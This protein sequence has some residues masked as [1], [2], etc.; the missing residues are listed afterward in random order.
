ME[1][2]VKPQPLRQQD[3]AAQ[4]EKL[5]CLQGVPVLVTGH[6]GFKGA[7][8]CQWLQRLGARVFGL[9]LDPPPDQPSL[10]DLARVAELLAEDVRGDIRDYALLSAV[11]SRVQPQV[12][13]H[14][15]AQALVQRSYAE[16]RYSFDVNVGGTVNLLE[17]ARQCDAVE[18]VVV[19]T[20]DKC[21]QN[22]GWLHG[23][24]ETDA[25][26]G[27]DPYSAS[28]AAAELAC[29]AY[30]DSFF[31]ASGLGLATARAGNVIGGGD[32]AAHRIVPDAVRA[33]EQG[34]PVPVRNPDHM[35]PWQHVLEPLLGY[36]LLG[37]QMMWSE[38]QDPVPEGPWNFGPP[39]DS[40]RR[41]RQV[42]EAFIEH[43]GEGDWEDLSAARQGQGE[44]AELLALSWERAYHQ[45]GWQPRWSFSETI[46]R[47]A[48][49]YR[50]QRQ[51][52]GDARALCAGEIEAY[53]QPHRG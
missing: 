28:K 44:E 41:V 25:L 14:L 35:R 5:H 30:R 8:L 17:A 6:T 47:T 32:W 31:G 12:V 29:A 51:H 20:S 21:Y 2:V 43:Y 45:L 1:D 42:V 33:L 7:W 15:A 11:L 26:G 3:L 40:C 4:L 19:V 39:V 46:G 50:R 37:A 49:W 9:A 24:R 13:F 48:R 16:P 38:R 27:K 52:D 34:L 36:L 10:F 23:Y 22:R 18:S 53:E